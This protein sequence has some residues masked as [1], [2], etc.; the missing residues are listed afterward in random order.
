[1]PGGTADNMSTDPIS[2]CLLGGEVAGR[3]AAAAG[4]VIARILKERMITP[5]F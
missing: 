3:V 4:F 5:Y 2:G 1:M